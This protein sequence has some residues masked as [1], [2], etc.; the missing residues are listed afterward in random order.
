MYAQVIPNMEFEF[1]SRQ[2]AT[3]WTPEDD[4]GLLLGVVKYGFGAYNSIKE[5]TTLSFQRNRAA[6]VQAEK[7]FIRLGKPLEATEEGME[8]IPQQSQVCPTLTWN[9]FRKF[10]IC[11]LKAGFDGAMMTDLSQSSIA[12]QLYNGQQILKILSIRSNSSTV[13]QA[14]TPNTPP[15]NRLKLFVKFSRTPEPLTNLFPDARALENHVKYLIDQVQ[16]FHF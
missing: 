14:P 12:P 13:L 5:D 16:F 15:A 9:G 11:G 8:A 3:W 2:L 7:E 4:K 10:D 1:A 6:I